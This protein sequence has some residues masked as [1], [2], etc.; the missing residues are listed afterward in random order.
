MIHQYVLDGHYIVLDVFSGSVHSVDPVAYDIISIYESMAA[1]QIVRV[2]SQKYP[3]VPKADIRECME[4]I[5]N[6]KAQGKLFTNDAFESRAGAIKAH[7]SVLKAL[8]L[9]VAHS[10]NLQC[11]Y[12]FADQGEYHGESA[13]MSYETGKQAFDFLVANSPGRRN[14]EVDFFGGEPLMNW[15]VVKRLVA[16]GRSIEAASDKNFRFT[17]TTNGVLL[18]DEVADF[19]N[20]EMHN[21]VLSLDGR[22]EVNDRLRVDRAGCGC[23]DRI[24]PRFKQFVQKRGEK[25]YYVRGTYTGYNT[26]FLHDIIHMADLGF[27]KLSM[28]PVVCAPKEAYALKESDL[29]VLFGQYEELAREMERRRKA[30]KPITFYHYMIDL[31]H[32]PCI[33]KRVSGCGSGSEYLAVTPQGDL[34]PCHQFVGDPK[35]LMGTIWEGITKP[36]IQE[37]FS[38]CTVYAR[39]ECRD[40]WAKLYCA[41][42]CAAN[43]YHATG[44]L[45]GIYEFGCKL[46]RKR[47][48][49]AIMLKVSETEDEDQ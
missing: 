36:A 15:D 37:D 11:R 14:L 35:F 7:T 8:C 10:C 34:Y 1:D 40:C 26:D 3:D 49:C 27:D 33:Y 29:P 2:I 28:E 24:V 12:C 23:Y 4:D 48:E 5:E 20:K 46:F 45:T 13:L 9:H 25:E 21:V 32:G 47:L 39:E 41:G 19:C 38:K 43:A 31:A 6:L 22:K 42:G 44:K 16:Y 18:D 17:L 30:G